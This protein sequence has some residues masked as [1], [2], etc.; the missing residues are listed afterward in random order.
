MHPGLTQ[1]HLLEPSASFVATLQ[2]ANSAQLFR[3]AG[4]S[5]PPSQFAAV[6]A[7]LLAFQRHGNSSCFYLGRGH[8]RMPRLNLQARSLTGRSS[9]RQPRG[10]GK[11][12]VMRKA[13]VGGGYCPSRRGRLRLGQLLNGFARISLSHGP[14]IRCRHQ[15][16]TFTVRT[17]SVVA[18]PNWS[19]PSVK[20]QSELWNMV[21]RLPTKFMIK[22]IGRR[23]R[24]SCSI[25][26]RAYAALLLSRDWSRTN[27]GSSL[28]AASS[29][30]GSGAPTIGSPSD[31]YSA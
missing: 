25:W 5:S 10:A 26:K 29:T 15:S 13:R 27:H 16:Y 14:P 12:V 9:R 2:S 21:D 20:V 4:N 23:H 8:P 6:A 24:G 7:F 31:C 22:G 18:M 3:I 11:V 1:E 28:Q 30:L 19:D 17:A